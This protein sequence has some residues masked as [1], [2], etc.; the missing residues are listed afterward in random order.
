MAT[1]S[2]VESIVNYTLTL[3]EFEAETLL[4][5]LRSIGGYDGKGGRREAINNI[6]D[7]LLDSGL[8]PKNFIA[9][10]AY[11]KEGGVK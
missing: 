2:K 8:V 10:S 6:S 11:V 1:V 4:G 5:V 3:S 7:T 9:G